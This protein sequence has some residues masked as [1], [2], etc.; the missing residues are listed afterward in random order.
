MKSN[1]VKLLII[2]S[3]VK[4]DDEDDLSSLIKRKNSKKDYSS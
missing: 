1:L 2:N 4:E 3:E